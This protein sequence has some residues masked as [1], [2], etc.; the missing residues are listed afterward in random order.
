V[1]RVS[2]KL[3]AIVSASGAYYLAYGLMIV[4]GLISMPIMTRVLSKAEYGLLGL[5]YLTATVFALVGG[6]GLG[7]AAVRLYGENLARGEAALRDLCGTLVGGAFAAGMIVAVALATIPLWIPGLASEPYLACL[8]LA[9]ALVVIRSMSGVAFQIY[10]AQERAG[11]HALTQVGQRYGSLIVALLF[12]F[13]F[14]RA[15]IT[16][17]IASLLVEVVALIIRLVDLAR[18]GVLGI[19]RQP[20]P[21]FS[22][23]IAYGLPLALAASAR[24]LLD[25]ADRFMIERLLGLDAVAMYAVPYDLTAKVG[26]ALAT[27]IQLAAVPIIFRLWVDEG[28]A[29]TSRFA[30]DVLSY[31]I[32]MALPIAV[33]YLI[34]SE[35]II[36]LLAS[37]KYRGAGELT[38]F[39]LPG[40]LLGTLNFLVV[41][42]LTVQ[43]RTGIVAMTVCGVA[44]LNVILNLILIPSWQ[45]TGAALATTASY[46]VL[47]VVN[48]YFAAGAIT[49]RPDYGILMKAA[50]ATT[51]S[52]LLL[53]QLDLLD[54]VSAIPLMVALALGV[55][56]AAVVF[57]VLDPRLRALLVAQGSGGSP[58]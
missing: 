45:L 33:L 15:A 17:I 53:Q 16:V 40:V 54:P 18:R 47:L 20:R 5:I 27:P 35:E 39:I 21:I 36:V 29:S 26:D 11:A 48:Y 30:S 24:F 43:K 3:P 32:A 14:R 49:L 4:A 50:L 58:A 28:Q 7:E 42:G 6:L 44:A 37:A 1:I 41:V 2:P 31:M 25:Y 46:A 12:L 57:A 34:Y 8:P 55:L 13:L 10:R 51:L 23:A 9:A 52:I 56:A 19:P 38:P 22:T